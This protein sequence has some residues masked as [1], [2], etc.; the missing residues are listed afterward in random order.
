M[1]YI[2]KFENINNEDLNENLIQSIHDYNISNF[3]NCIENGA[4]VN[5]YQTRL[6]SF[7]LLETVATDS[8]IEELRKIRYNMAKILLD[9]GA[10]PDKVDMN[11][12]TTL[13]LAT[14]PVAYFDIIKLLI[15]YNADWNIKKNDIDF[16]DNLNNGG[17]ND[18]VDTLK[19]EYPEKYKKYL[20]KKEADKYNL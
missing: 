19:K 18:F 4:D 16:I 10:N 3:N 14:E 12:Y 9:H 8:K 2:K 17:Y 20:I 1:K 11:D 5:Y 15:E 7:P 6:D 13:I